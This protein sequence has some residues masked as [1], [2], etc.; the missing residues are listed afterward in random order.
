M[1]LFN[2]TADESSMLAPLR[3]QGAAAALYNS[4]PKTRILGCSRPHGLFSE[5]ENPFLDNIVTGILL[6]LAAWL[7]DALLF[8]ACFWSDGTTL[9]AGKVQALEAHA[10]LQQA[11]PLGARRALGVRGAKEQAAGRGTRRRR[12]AVLFKAA[13]CLSFGGLLSFG[14]IVLGNS[15]TRKFKLE[16]TPALQLVLVK[17]SSDPVAERVRSSP[18]C[19]VLKY[20]YEGHFVQY[21][22]FLRRCRIVALERKRNSSNTAKALGPELIW[23]SYEVGDKGTLSVSVTANGW[24]HSQMMLLRAKASEDMVT[25]SVMFAN[26]TRELIQAYAFIRNV[27]IAFMGD[28]AEFRS[29]ALMIDNSVATFSFQKRKRFTRGSSMYL[30]DAAAELMTVRQIKGKPGQLFDASEFLRNETYAKG[31]SSVLCTLKL[32]LV[33]YPVLIIVCA[34]LGLLRLGVE[35]LRPNMIWNGVWDVYREG[36]GGG[37]SALPV[38]ETEVGNVT[39]KLVHDAS[40]SDRESA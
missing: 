10:R 40:Q 34:S 29:E 16:D 31:G 30:A 8:D 24:V 9:R 7:L 37:C 38:Y 15:W 23:V 26:V 28:R 3:D 22:R 13:A 2:N 20:E 32:K 21:N 18:Q 25:P 36:V 35:A 39:R 5:F 11:G 17:S 33:P 19:D 27:T 1:A 14:S 4:L 12:Y 6:A